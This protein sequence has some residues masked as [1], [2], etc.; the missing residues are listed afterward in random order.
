MSDKKEKKRTKLTD[1]ELNS[2]PLEQK[3]NILL[4]RK[5]IN[6]NTI[7]LL[8]SV[9]LIIPSICCCSSIHSAKTLF[10]IISWCLAGLILL[11]LILIG[12]LDSEDKLIEE[13]EIEKRKK[14]IE[15]LKEEALAR[16]EVFVDMS[17]PFILK[18]IRRDA[19]ECPICGEKLEMSWPYYNTTETQKVDLP[20]VYVK[21]S[22]GNEVEQAVTYKRVND[23][24]IAQRCH[25]PKCEYSF[26][27]SSVSYYEHEEYTV[28]EDDGPSSRS[29]WFR[30]TYNVFALDKGK[31]T[32]ICYE[33]LMKELNKA[34]HS[35]DKIVS[36]NEFSEKKRS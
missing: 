13:L 35:K 12:G 28:Q 7:I 6:I 1:E 24:F 31:I 16:G 26:Y 8:C 32:E 2:L 11:S 21:K 25:C 20:G 18:F 23:D 22:Y 27:S 9:V 33:N 29:G 5:M 17:I 36:S 34:L 10:T 14:E 30:K 19:S 15:K 4:E 3:K